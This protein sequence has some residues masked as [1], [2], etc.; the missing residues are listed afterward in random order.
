MITLKPRRQ[1]K[2]Q[3][4]I[5]ALLFDHQTGLIARLREKA[6]D[7]NESRRLREALENVTA[8]PLSFK[9]TA[10]EALDFLLTVK[11]DAPQTVANCPQIWEQTQEALHS[12]ES[13]PA[14]QSQR[15]ARC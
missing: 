4:S 2:P 11:L 3:T 15:R 12:H 6:E 8:N 7:V 13:A 9:P 5:F 14:Q 10:P 1:A